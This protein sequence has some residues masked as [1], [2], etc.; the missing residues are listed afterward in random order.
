M[1]EAERGEVCLLRG[2]ERRR[3]GLRDRMV[4]E[5]LRRILGF[6]ERAAM[7]EL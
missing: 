2:G 4:R 3:R 6:R 1:G 7:A 5:K